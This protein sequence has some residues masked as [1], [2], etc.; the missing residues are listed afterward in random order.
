MKILIADKLAS[1]V[2][3]ALETMGCTVFSDPSLNGESLHASIAKNNPQVIVVR[4]TRLSAQQ[5]QAGR[6]LT[7]IIRAGAG[8]N[9]I[10]LDTASD[11]GV[12]VANCPGK[13]A[14][15]VAELTWGHILNADRRI[16]DNVASLRAGN[17]KKKTFAKGPKGL[18]GR[19]LG[20]VGFGAI[21]RAVHKRGR[22]FGMTTIVFDPLLNDAEAASMGVQRA[23]SPQEVA[24][25]AD[26]LTV[27]V[28]LNEHTR[29]LISASVLE[30]LQPGCIFVNT[31]RGEIVDETALAT[32]VARGVKAGLDVF[33][34]EPNQDGPWTKPLATMNGV[35]GTHHIG[36]STA[37]ATEAVGDEIVRIVQ[38]FLETGNVPNC[39]NLAVTVHATHLLVVR[40]ADKVGVLAGV[41]D[42][43][44]GA[45]INVQEME[46][47]VFR[48]ANAACAR[49]QVG[50]APSAALMVEIENLSS[51]F[52]T[53][54]VALEST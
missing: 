16:A 30:A 37:E 3:P 24:A 52:A 17:W 43:L 35:Y 18:R 50:R 29:G 54:L 48:G 31:S 13:N 41:L 9:T 46:N 2:L 32:A 51:V 49:I 19:T 53:D 36:A 25:A 11:R 40:H 21:G 22:A 44:K 27:H 7:L 47:I 1:T 10:D 45:E 12:Y 28:G 34:E 8:V 5:I 42:A 14:V 6:A 33:C 23:E 20:I 15:A 4:S 39:V 38:T 26:V